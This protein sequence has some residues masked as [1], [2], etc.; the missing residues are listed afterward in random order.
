[1]ISKDMN[2][3][4]LLNPTIEEDI[5]KIREYAEAKM[6]LQALKVRKNYLESMLYNKNSDLSESV[7]TTMDGVSKPVHD[8]DDDHLKNIVLYLNKQG[9]YNQRIVDEYQKRFDALPLLTA[10]EDKDFF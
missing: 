1:M 9:K 7:W 8:L 6:E 4:K 3:Y 5:D 10:P 2:K